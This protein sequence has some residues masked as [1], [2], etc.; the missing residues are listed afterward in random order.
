MSRCPLLPLADRLVIKADLPETRR[1]SLVL[2]SAAPPT[3]G[4]VV[5]VGPDVAHARARDYVVFQRYNTTV[6]TVDD[7]PWTLV[8]ES[9][10]LCKLA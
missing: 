5:A 8:R 7:A 10:V 3:R 6:V 2:V 9:D 4:K 1:G